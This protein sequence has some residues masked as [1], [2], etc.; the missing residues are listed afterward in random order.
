MTWS[1]FP[2]KMHPCKR[3]VWTSKPNMVRMS[4]ILSCGRIYG[5]NRLCI[6]LYAFGACENSINIE[7][8]GL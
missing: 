5:L 7:H 4:C 1:G 3:T 8:H 6:G 2:T